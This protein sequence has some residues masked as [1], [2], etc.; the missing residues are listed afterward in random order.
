MAA[1]NGSALIVLNG[2][3]G[4][5]MRK[6]GPDTKAADGGWVSQA[7]T[8]PAPVA[9]SGTSWWTEP[10]DRQVFDAKARSELSRMKQSRFAMLSQSGTTPG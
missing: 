6:H 9:M 2:R 5:D 10:L 3:R 4:D 8:T 7:I 1:L